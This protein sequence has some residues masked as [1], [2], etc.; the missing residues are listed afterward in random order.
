MNAYDPHYVPVHALKLMGVK[1]IIINDLDQILM[2]QRSDKTS[3]AH[4]WDFAGGGVDKGEDPA[5]AAVRE[6]Q[7]ETG[8]IISTPRLLSAFHGYTDDKEYVLLG[9]SAHVQTADVRI[10]WEHESYRWMNLDEV[11]HIELPDA[12]RSTLNAY[13]TDIS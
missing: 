3:R 10:S 4:G 6:V 12:H 13:M 7:E 8:L 2:L 1:V 9:Y 5:R 11:G